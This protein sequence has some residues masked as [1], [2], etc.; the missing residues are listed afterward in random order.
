MAAG[1]F[2]SIE[3]AQNAMCLSCRTFTPDISAAAVYN[4]LYSLYRKAY[5]ALGTRQAERASLGDILPE[6]QAIAAMRFH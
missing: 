1:A 5:F 2:A 4:R 6:L 3:E